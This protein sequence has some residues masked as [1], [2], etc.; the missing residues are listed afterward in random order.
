MNDCLT[1]FYVMHQLCGIAQM[2]DKKMGD[3]MTK[4]VEMLYKQYLDKG[5][6]PPERK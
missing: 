2:V 5:G 1:Q 3:R 4:E 6:I